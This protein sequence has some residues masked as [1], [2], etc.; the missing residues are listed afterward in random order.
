ERAVVRIAAESEPA[1]GSVIAIAAHLPPKRLSCSSSATAAMAACP[2]PC[3]GIVSSSPTSPQHSSINPSRL[4]MLLPLRLPSSPD[5]EPLPL[6][7]LPPPTVPVPAQQLHSVGADRH[8]AL[9]AQPPRERYLASER[10]T[11]VD[12]AGGAIC[13]QAHALELDRDVGDGERHGLAVGNRFSERG[14]FVDVRDHVVEH[15]L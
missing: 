10:E 13:D 6:E 12:T 14:A 7:P 1:S 4:A 5:L 15:G 8:S 2:S 9:A 3:R 11:L